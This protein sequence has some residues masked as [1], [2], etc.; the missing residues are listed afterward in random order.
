MSRRATLAVIALAAAAAGFT[1]A[2]NTRQSSDDDQ[3][4]ATSAAAGP[5]FA[6]LGWRES[7]GT[8]REHLV[9]RV[10]SLRVRERGWTVQ[11]SLEN[12]TKKAYEITPTLESPFGLMILSTGDL[13]EL[14]RLNEENA[15]PAVRPATRYDPRLPAALAPGEV[16]VG[17]ISAPGS[18]VANGWVRVVFGALGPVG[19]PN[20]RVAWIT[21]HTYRLQR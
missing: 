7:Y 18:L 19:E 12:R 16:W 1:L 17:K 14:V 21:D 10:E 5:Q 4:R 3:R 9:F 13:N 6:V 8:P 11:L 15:L 2:S 20:D